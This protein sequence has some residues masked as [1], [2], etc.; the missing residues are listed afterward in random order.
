MKILVIIPTHDRRQFIE[1]AL[2]SLRVQTRRADRVIVTGNVMPDDSYGHGSCATDWIAFLKSKLPLVDRLNR[3]VGF[4]RCD[5]F[6][7]L[8]DDD[9]LDPEYIAKTSALM[10]S[11]GADIVTTSIRWF[12]EDHASP[13]TIMDLAMRRNV[14]QVMGEPHISSL[15]R[16]ASWERAGKYQAASY[17]DQDLWLRMKAAGCGKVEWVQEPLL[18]YR[19]HEGQDS[20]TVTAGEHERIQ[21]E[22]RERHAKG[23][24]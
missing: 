5:R 24:L 9:K 2:D 16:R 12:G 7:I 22:T 13:A 8:S 1:A 10:E 15:V 20:Q 18:W 4:S 17:F 23:R 14:F 3:A 21:R 6:L 19:V 11:T